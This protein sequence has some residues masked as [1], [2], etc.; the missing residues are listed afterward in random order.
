V[1]RHDRE[2]H[3]PPT[4]GGGPDNDVADVADTLPSTKLAGLDRWIL[5][6][7]RAVIS[8]RRHLED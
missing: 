5:R 7:P 1:D 3:R 6:A 4:N 2:H 8:A